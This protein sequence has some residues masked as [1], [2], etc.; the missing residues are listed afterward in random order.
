LDMKITPNV[1]NCICNVGFEL[2]FGSN[3]RQNW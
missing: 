1:L 3:Q 2:R